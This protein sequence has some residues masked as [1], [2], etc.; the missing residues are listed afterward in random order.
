MFDE[1]CRPLALFNAEHPD[2]AD[3]LH[4]FGVDDGEGY[5]EGQNRWRFIGAYL[6]YGQWKQA[7]LG[8]IKALAD[9]Y[10]VT[11]EPVYARK[12]AILL[13]RVADLYP[14]F[15][16]KTQ[17]TVYERP[18]A[19]GYVSTWHDACEE[20]RNWRWPMTRF[21]AGWRAMRP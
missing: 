2:P 13:D 8:G 3:P 18:G 6:V 12:A 7:V 5:V 1:A 17:A 9:A 10:I 21:A 4:R 19:A 14:G 11:G 20:T 15:D 16:Y